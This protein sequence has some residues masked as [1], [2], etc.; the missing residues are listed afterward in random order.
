[1]RITE[2]RERTIPLGSGMRNAGIRF[3]AMTAS[4]I[5][6]HTDETVAGKQLIGLAFDSIGRYGHGALLKERF[7]PR[8]LAADPDFYAD[9]ATGLI[10]PERAFVAMMVNEKGGGHGERAGAVGLLDC[11]LWDLRAKAEGRPLHTL[12]AERVGNGSPQPA[13]VYGSGG[14]YGDAGVSGL[15]RELEGYRSLGF[16]RFKIKIGGAPLADD[17][18]RIEAALAVAGD[19]RRLAVD[20][21]AVWDT[22]EAARWIGALAPYDLAWVEE[23]VPPLDF[24]GLAAVSRGSAVPLATGENL[25]SAEETDLLLGFGGLD[26]A[27]DWLQMDVSLSYGP[28]GY[29][30]ILETVRR[31]GWAWGRVLPHAGHLLALHAVVGFGLGGHEAAPSP[32][33]AYGGFAEDTVFEDG[34]AIPGNSP[35]T[36]IE[37]KPNLYRLFSGLVS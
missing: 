30:A 3:D 4:A 28:S 5:A 15:V 19:G 11:A 36:G 37:A 6:V 10:D 22:D 18:A 20:A 33:L 34:H 7:A 25:F 14:H 1:M 32:E 21:N 13:P 9:P 35:G 24:A 16:D 2:I 12:L 23:P 29:L 31:H 27:R 26:P 8:L 17:L